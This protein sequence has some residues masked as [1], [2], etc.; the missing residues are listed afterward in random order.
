MI[1]H[2][3]LGIIDTS[4]NGPGPPNSVTIL[5]PY[6]RIPGDGRSNGEKPPHGEGGRSSS[7]ISHPTIFGGS[8]MDV[9]QCLLDR[10]RRRHPEYKRG[11]LVVN[12]LNNAQ[13]HLE[14]L[15]NQLKD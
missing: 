4:L 9:H 2:R 5:R 10:K 3:S 12:N 13:N 1:K 6:S 7:A 8:L 11:N 15:P 14:V